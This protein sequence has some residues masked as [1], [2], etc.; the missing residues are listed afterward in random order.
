M[1]NSLGTLYSS[2][3]Q[4]QI[5]SKYQKEQIPYFQFFNP[6][7]CK[8]PGFGLK[9]TEALKAGFKP[10]S[11]WIET[12]ASFSDDTTEEIYTTQNPSLLVLCAGDLVIYDKTE[13]LTLPHSRE[14]W[15][16]KKGVLT[17][18]GEKRYICSKSAI[19]LPVSSDDKKILSH[20][21]LRFRATNTAGFGLMNEINKHYNNYRSAI[22]Y[23]SARFPAV[24][25]E[26]YCSIFKPIITIGKASNAQGAKSASCLVE[27]QDPILFSGWTNPNAKK[28]SEDYGLFEGN[29]CD[30]VFGEYDADH[31]EI[32]ALTFAADDYLDKPTEQATLQSPNGQAALTPA[33]NYIGAE[34]VGAE[35]EVTF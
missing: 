32:V 7:I 23:I 20:Q 26:N 25:D 13:N 21:F 24:P 34:Y 2:E 33:A 6:Q 3:Y 4:S 5:Q 30:R 31:S 1:S 11:A 16:E 17:E 10:D 9:K 12:V 22:S 27:K 18:E 28:G 35:A 14:D 8:D 29:F 19:L 15:A